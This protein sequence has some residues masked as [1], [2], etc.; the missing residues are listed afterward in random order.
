MARII[1]GA[2]PWSAEGGEVGALVLHGFTGNPVSMRPLAESLAEAGLAVELP[3]LPGHGTSWREL[4]RTTW[5]DW[6]REARAALE[7]LASRTHRRLVVGL[8]VGGL[9]G[10][11]LA[12]T[13]P[14]LVD[15]VVAIN[16]AL[17]L[18]HHPLLRFVGALKHVLPSYPSPTTD[19]ITLP[20]VS[21]HAYDRVPL[22]A[23]HSLLELQ[24]AVALED[25]TA[26]LL[27]MTSR[28]DHVVPPEA[29]GEVLARVASVDREQI[30]LE[31]SLHVATLD[32][33]ADLVL[34]RTLAFAERV[35]GAHR[36]SAAR[37]PAAHE[38]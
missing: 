19:D 11:H 9:L 8:S 25:V 24:C 20:G 10:L 32:A 21:E 23:L 26:P 37:Q 18:H 35:A 4:G 28:T 5:H 13:R 22:A 30:W 31:R 15:G 33:D 7:I 16:P 14:G 12:A 38:A 6:S 34:A 3:R 2:E 29:S 17:R 27:V 1:P 36:R